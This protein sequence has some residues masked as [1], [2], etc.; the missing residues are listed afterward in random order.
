MGEFIFDTIIC[1]VSKRLYHY[2]CIHTQ[3]KLYARSQEL[4]KNWDEK[5]Q[6]YVIRKYDYITVDLY[7]FDHL[8][9]ISF[10]ATLT[11]FILFNALAMYLQ[12]KYAPLMYT[13]LSALASH[14][15]Y[16][17]SITKGFTVLIAILVPSYILGSTVIILRDPTFQLSSPCQP[18]DSSY[19]SCVPESEFATEHKRQMVSLVAS[20]TLKLTA[21]FLYVLASIYTVK[22]ARNP[23]VIFQSDCRLRWIE[24][25]LLWSVLTAIHISI[26][27]A[28]LP[29]LI[30]TI[31][32]P[33]YL[34]FYVSSMIMGLGIM[35]L[36]FILAFHLFNQ[37]NE[38]RMGKIKLLLHSFEVIFFY[39]MGSGILVTL[40]ILYYLFL[41][42][43][44]SMI[45]L[46]GILFSLVPPLM[47][48]VGLVIIKTK[49]N[50]KHKLTDESFEEE[51]LLIDI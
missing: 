42:G 35:A 15:D 48:S 6:G 21:T 33:M 1:I 24:V 51:P 8:S 27:L 9:D 5:D 4:P 39:L 2:A 26:G 16:S 12:L 40:F 41:T 29:I 17:R 30:F 11:C 36:P 22:T 28:G 50:N 31:L 46:K 38:Q 25:Y 23:G 47:I 44:A 3:V 43:G 37:Q 14:D 19:Y 10:D 45:G 7:R 13:K 32:M 18:L 34:I 49:M 20:A